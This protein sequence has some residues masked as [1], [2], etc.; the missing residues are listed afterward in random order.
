MKIKVLVLKL[1]PEASGGPP[2][3]F[4]APFPEKSR[5]KLVV[6]FAGR[7]P[8]RFLAVSGRPG[9]DS[10][11]PGGGQKRLTIM[12]NRFPEAF[13]SGTRFRPRFCL[14]FKRFLWFSTMENHEKSMAGAV[15]SACRRKIDEFGL[16]PFF[17][18]KKH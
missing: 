16:G 13:F 6:L 7:A 9:G 5:K 2:G 12:K 4:D 17:G 10:R 11:A 3:M 15:D 18:T 1:V 14:D 8:E